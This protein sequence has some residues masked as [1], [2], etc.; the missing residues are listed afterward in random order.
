VTFPQPPATEIDPVATREPQTLP[1]PSPVSPVAVRPGE[2][3]PGAVTT[4]E[5]GPGQF[6]KKPRPNHQRTLQILKAQ[7]PAQKLAQVFQLNER[8]LGL[9][10]AGLRQRFPHLAEE[11]LHQLSLQMRARCH[12]RTS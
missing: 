8:V 10:R 2:L 3:S 6:L 5:A 1:G 12:N 4:G 11:E 9:M 7:T